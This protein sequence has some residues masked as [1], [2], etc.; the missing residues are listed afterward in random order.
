[1]NGGIKRNCCFDHSNL[2]LAN[3]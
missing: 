1:M 3:K 2:H